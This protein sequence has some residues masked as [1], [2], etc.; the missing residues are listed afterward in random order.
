MAEREA[1]LLDR[2]INQGDTA[3]A[4]ELLAM[5][6]AQLAKLEQGTRTIK[7][8]LLALQSRYGFAG[9]AADNT[10]NREGAEN[11]EH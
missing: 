9:R 8:L 5:A 4:N 1:A 7:H 6:A 11:G 3:A 10:D 2:A